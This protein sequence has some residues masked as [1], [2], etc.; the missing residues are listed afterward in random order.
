[1]KAVTLISGGLDGTL[2]A[3]VVQNLGIELIPVHF[4]IPFCHDKEGDDAD[5]LATA[6]AVLGLAVREVELADGFLDVIRSPRYGFGSQMN[7]CIDCRILMLSKAR[8]LMEEC[9]AHFVV[10]GEVLGQRPM[11]QHRQALFIVAKRAG[12]EGLVV[13]PLSARLLP[14]TIPEQQGWLRRETLLDFSGRGRRSQL[15]LAKQFAVRDYAQP[16]GGCLLTD[17]HFS[18]RLKDIVEHGEMN[19]DNVELLKTGRHFRLSKHTKLTV[20][21]NEKENRE[22]ER[23]M[24]P[25][26]RLFMPHLLVGPT[27]LGRGVFDAG[28][29]EMSMGIVAAY[30]GVAPDAAAQIVCRSKGHAEILRTDIRPLDKSDF[31][32]L[33]I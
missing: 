24:Q 22:L 23:M 12:L 13:R 15:A 10:T 8:D 29:V 14:E 9:G 32:V 19:L 30:C 27:A 5:I 31:A 16:A 2:A 17:P 25:D 6:S 1:M 28:L 33:R 3:K 26:D 7:P 4:R 18:R 21:R 11:S 20:G